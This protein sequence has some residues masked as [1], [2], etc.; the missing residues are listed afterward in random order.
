MVGVVGVAGSP[1]CG[2][3]TTLDIGLALKTIGSCPLSG[4]PRSGPTG[5]LSLDRPFQARACSPKVS[6]TA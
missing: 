4:R 5:P 1:S 2:A 6:P 3:N